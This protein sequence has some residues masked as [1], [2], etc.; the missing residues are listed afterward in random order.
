MI[1]LGY[2]CLSPDDEHDMDEDFHD[3]IP[4]GEYEDLCEV[5]GFQ[6]HLPDDYDCEHDM[7]DIPIS[8]YE[9]AFILANTKTYCEVMG[10]PCHLPADDDCDMDVDVVCD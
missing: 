10:Y 6:C 5:V 8:K 2:Q 7:D 3:D 4:I 9:A 1:V